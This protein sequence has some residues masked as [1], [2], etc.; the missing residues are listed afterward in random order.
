MVFTLLEGYTR[1]EEQTTEYRDRVKNSR[2]YV[3]LTDKDKISQVSTK[4]RIEK[5]DE[6]LM[7]TLMT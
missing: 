4:L 2:P 1:E 7:Q 6:D 5:T 3:R